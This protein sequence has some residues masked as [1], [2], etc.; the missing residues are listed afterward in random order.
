MLIVI[1]TI[2]TVSQSGQPIISM[3]GTVTRSSKE[4]ELSESSYK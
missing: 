3:H 1:T 2:L 4:C